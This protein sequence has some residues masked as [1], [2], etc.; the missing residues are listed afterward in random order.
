MNNIP[1]LEA[2]KPYKEQFNVKYDLPLPTNTPFGNLLLTYSE[3]VVRTECLNELITNLY[4]GF[5][6]HCELVKARGGWSNPDEGFKHR[7]EIEQVFYWLHK[8]A[9]EVISLVY[10]LN[11]FEKY[12]KYPT[13]INTSCIGDFIKSGDHFDDSLDKH[14]KL[15]RILNSVSN[16]YKHSIM[17]T[18][19]NAYRGRDEPVVFAYLLKYN[20]LKNMPQYHNVSL[21]AVINAFNSFLIDIKALLEFKLAAISTKAN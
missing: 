6:A 18:Q 16:A 20:D 17:N 11:Y 13:K 4:I 10:I 2:L 7:F 9:D 21:R 15:L 1:L 14:L 5:T 3:I 8:T 19:L 12:D